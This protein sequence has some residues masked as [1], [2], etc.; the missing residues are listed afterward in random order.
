MHDRKE[1][2]IPKL[3][4]GCDYDERRKKT[5]EDGVFYETC[6]DAVDYW[7]DDWVCCPSCG[8]FPIVDEQ[9]GDIRYEHNWDV[10]TKV[11]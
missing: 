8:A 1:E 10:M 2:K 7:D 9:T 6:S 4:I 11:H 5:L 3:V